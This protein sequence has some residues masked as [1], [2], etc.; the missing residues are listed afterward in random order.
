[1]LDHLLEV[2]DAV[3]LL[4]HVVEEREVGV[5]LLD[6]LADEAV[7]L[8]L[9]GELFD[10]LEGLVVALHLSGQLG[11]LLLGFALLLLLPDAQLRVFLAALTLQVQ[12]THQNVAL[13]QSSPLVLS[14]E[15]PSLIFA[16]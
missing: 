9:V 1:M 4:V 5:L 8:L 10:A 13:V 12:S 3:V 2:L 11:A 15:T 16:T 6:E 7:E 14:I